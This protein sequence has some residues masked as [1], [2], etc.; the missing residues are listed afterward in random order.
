MTVIYDAFFLSHWT[1][2]PRPPPPRLVGDGP[3]T[4]R[5]FWRMHQSERLREL[6]A[7]PASLGPM[8]LSLS[9]CRNTS[10]LLLF[11]SQ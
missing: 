5:T 1:E 6:V 7:Q 8:D 10:S 11:L 3:A 9:P 4:N 2:K